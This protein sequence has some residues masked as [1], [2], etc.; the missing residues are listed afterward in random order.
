MISNLFCL[1]NFQNH[2]KYLSVVYRYYRK[3]L[4]KS[5]LITG[6]YFKED[7]LEDFIS[8]INFIPYRSKIYDDCIKLIETYYTPNK[9][10]ELIEDS[11]KK[12]LKGF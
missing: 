2:A 1:T 8:K 10:F 6:F 9:Q 7:D 5:L 4:L 3:I 12:Y 11:V